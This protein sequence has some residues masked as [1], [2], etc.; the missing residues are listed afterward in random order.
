MAECVASGAYPMVNQYLGADSIYPK[1]VLC[2]TPG[3]M[4]EKTIWWGNLS[5]DRKKLL[6]QDSRVLMQ[7]YDCRKATKN[8]REFIEEIVQ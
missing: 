6:R 5:D 3:E 8:M 7:K 1:D 2:K 4:V